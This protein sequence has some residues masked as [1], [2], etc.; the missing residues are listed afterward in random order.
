MN[1][2]KI[3]TLMTILISFNIYASV[4]HTFNQGT[5]IEASKINDNFNR[6]KI[7]YQTKTISANNVESD[8]NFYNLE[9]G[10]TYRLSGQIAFNDNQIGNGPS[11]SCFMDIMNGANQIGK[12]RNITTPEVN[13][14]KAENV[15]GLNIVFKATATNNSVTF[16]RNS[17]G[18]IQDGT[19]VT[20]EEAP[21]HEE[22]TDFNN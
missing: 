16:L 20:L 10:M 15:F 14:G 4:P 7:K 19:R 12:I 17:C 6:G 13:G 22:T 5:K 9:D 2:N 1:F 18:L 8:L 21:L 11:F 3:F